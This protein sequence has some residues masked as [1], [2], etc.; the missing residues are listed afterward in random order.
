MTQPM[1]SIRGL[2]KIFGARDKDALRH[3]QSGMGKQEL[4]TD[5]VSL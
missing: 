5:Q 4:L 2:Y 3:V 1:V